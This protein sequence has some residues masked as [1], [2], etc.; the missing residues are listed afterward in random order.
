MVSRSF[1]FVAVLV[2]AMLARASAS[3]P[4][5]AL[6]RIVFEFFQYEDDV[7]V[8]VNSELESPLTSVSESAACPAPA[9]TLTSAGGAFLEWLEGRELPGIA[10]LDRAW[11]SN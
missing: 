8:L 10:A 7:V 5:F 9:A 6:N 2:F 1:P 4:T 3:A 11:D